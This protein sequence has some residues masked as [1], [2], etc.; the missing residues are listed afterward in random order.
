MEFTSRISTYAQALHK[1]RFPWSSMDL[2]FPPINNKC[3]HELLLISF[4]LSP[5][6]NIQ[7][8]SALPKIS[9]CLTTPFRLRFSSFS[10]VAIPHHI[11]S[12]CLETHTSRE[13]T[14]RQSET[15]AVAKSNRKSTDAKKAYSLGH[16]PIPTKAPSE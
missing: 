1:G 15:I 6:H 11:K 5:F 10:F 16:F 2:L 9:S 12:F 3:P 13:A 8:I 14:R 4:P 7:H